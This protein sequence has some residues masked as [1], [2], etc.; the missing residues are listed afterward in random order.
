V[1]LALA[2]SVVVCA[3]NGLFVWQTT[4]EY[5]GGT[6]L[7]A[8]LLIGSQFASFMLFVAAVP[9]AVWRPTRPF[10]IGLLAAGVIGVGLYFATDA[11]WHQ[12]AT[13]M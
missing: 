6:I 9:F 4:G 10:A 7:L 8:G 3:I 2:W 5:N 13:S 11:V 12:L 1:A